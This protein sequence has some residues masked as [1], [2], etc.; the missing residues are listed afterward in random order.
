MAWVYILRGSN[1][2]HYIGSAVDLDARMAQH[3]RGHTYTT[4]RL[5]E[6]IEIV[7]SREV[8]TLSEARGIERALKAKKNPQLAIYHLQGPTREEQSE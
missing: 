3:L 4:K 1:G 8:A 2:R 7:A 5:G 6:N